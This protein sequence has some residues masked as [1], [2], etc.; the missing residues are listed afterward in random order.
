MDVLSEVLRAVRLSGAI[1][2]K[3]TAAEPWISTNPSMRQ[4]GATMMPG[5]E[6]V[7][8]FHILIQG[9]AWAMPENGAGGDGVHP[10]LWSEFACQ[11]FGQ[12]H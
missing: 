7:I 3:V 1:Y 4:V 2:F 12:H 9:R 10:D 6:H 11:G 8:P 5:A